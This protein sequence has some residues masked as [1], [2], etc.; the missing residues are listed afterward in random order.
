M[1]ESLA[2]DI[3]NHVATVQLQ[4]PGRGNAMGPAF[5][6]EMAPAFAELDAN[7]QV[8]A[9]V[10]QGSGEHFSYGLD[11]MGMMPEIGPFL[12]GEQ[13]AAQRTALLAF[14]ERMQEAITAVE[15]CS[16][17]VIAAVHGWCIGGGVDLISACDVRVCASNARFSVRE[18]RLGM[19]ADVGSLQR[20]PAIIGQ[21]HTREL[22]LTGRDFDAEHAAAIG[23]VTAVHANPAETFDAAQRIA[24]EIAANPPLA[25]QG[26]KRVLNYSASHPSGDGLAYVAAWNAA[27][28]PSNDLVE[29]MTAFAQ[30]RTPTFT[31]T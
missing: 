9:V 11:L 19:V 2:I 16:K 3:A 13:K 27:F 15:R 29:A 14:I 8:R 4:G 12:Q 22:A 23:L 6:R 30:H 17:P 5:W 10:V 1:H 25:V 28:L 18:V 21:G 26:T 7:P 31:G 20:L 24:S